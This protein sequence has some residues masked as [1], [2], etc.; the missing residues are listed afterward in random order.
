[1]PA[2]TNAFKAALRTDEILVG[3][4]LGFA[5]SYVAEAAATADFDWF[6]IDGEHAPNDIPT[7]LSQIAVVQGAGRN[8]VV[9]LPI[10]EGWMVKIR[11]SVPDQLAELMNSDVYAEHC[12]SE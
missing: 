2:P 9:R 7:I 10:G 1:M 4:W 3:T 11:L 8:A 12:A 5:D 6:L